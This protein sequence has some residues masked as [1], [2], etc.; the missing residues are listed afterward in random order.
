MRLL[1]Q[2]YT[3]VL[4]QWVGAIKLVKARFDVARLL[5]TMS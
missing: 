5:C 1:M 2:L 3:G 4:A